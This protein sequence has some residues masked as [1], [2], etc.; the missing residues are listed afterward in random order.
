MAV[1][2]S[3]GVGVGVGVKVGDEVR[4]TVSVGEVWTAILVASGL[5]CCPESGSGVPVRQYA[6]LISSATKGRIPI[7]T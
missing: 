2:V 3:V 6:A 5:M 1:A 4:V 7:L